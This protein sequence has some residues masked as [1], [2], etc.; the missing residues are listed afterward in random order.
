MLH[1]Y[2]VS[3]FVILRYACSARLPI[4]VHGVHTVVLDCRLLVRRSVTRDVEILLD[5]PVIWTDFE[6][7]VNPNNEICNLNINFWS[8]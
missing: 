5:M 8:V 7:L 4:K 2:F 1:L 6:N 3:M